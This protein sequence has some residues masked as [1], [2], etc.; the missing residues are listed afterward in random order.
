MAERSAQISKR[1][2]GSALEGLYERYNSRKY[3]D[4][5]PLV[6]LYDYPDIRDREIAGMVASSLAFG[7]VR[8]IMGSIGKVLGFMGPSPHEYLM[9]VR[10]ERLS[11]ELAGFRH[12]WA[13]PEDVEAL[14]LGIRD[15]VTR[16]GSLERCFLS[17]HSPD[18][19]DVVEGMTMLAASI[20]C[21]PS[22]PGAC[23]MPDPCRSSACK[24]LNLFLRWMVRSDR[25]DPG[26]WTGVDPSKLLIPL[27]V[28]M[29]RFGLLLG[30]TRR[31][32]ADLA[33]AREV[34]AAMRELSPEDP[35]K[36]DFAVT[37][38]GIRRD[39]DR[40]QLLDSLAAGS[41]A[42]YRKGSG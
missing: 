31:K 33:T 38:L 9:N 27:D 20:V 7:N 30:M 41:G 40:E 32:Q 6:F 15:A 36:Y 2:L 42:A 1:R 25:V 4:P 35:V 18:D 12:R 29:H 24:R 14:L 39:F 13:G 37:R 10:R 8:Q 34:T 3:V 11:G 22:G 16:H 19:E 5:D 23:L 21:P 26:G 28:H 17:G